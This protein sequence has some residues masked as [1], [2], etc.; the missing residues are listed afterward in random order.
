MSQPSIQPVFVDTV[1]VDSDGVPLRLYHGTRT[2]ITEFD[3]AK[4]VDGGFH[5]GTIDQAKMRTHGAEKRVIEVEIDTRRPRRMFDAGG[6]W[7]QKIEDV[8]R[9]GFDA[10]V[11]L[12]R[13]EGVPFEA[14]ERALAKKIDLDA[15]SD[16]DFRRFVPE[17]RDSWIVF[18]K[19]KIKILGEVQLTD[20]RAIIEG[21][22]NGDFDHEK[23]AERLDDLKKA[24]PVAM[25]ELTDAILHVRE[26][27]AFGRVKSWELGK[28]EDMLALAFAA[29][30]EVKG[31][32][33]LLTIRDFWQCKGAPATDILGCVAKTE[34]VFTFARPSNAE[35]AAALLR[36]IQ[37]GELDPNKICGDVGT[38]LHYA[39]KYDAPE[40]VAV[41]L[42]NGAD[43]NIPN[44]KGQT[45][46]EMAVKF[47]K[48]DVLKPF[49]AK[50]ADLVIAK[51]LR[52]VRQSEPA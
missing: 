43:M 1:A 48:P 7:K 14:V 22:V 30:A 21:Y 37:E 27:G 50:R 23:L 46:Y 19:A 15:I 33:D 35:T 42:A 40:R 34:C 49:H 4:T 13:Y 3:N 51:V 12:N 11:Y 52:G 24:G 44:E 38:P 18:D 39:V 31:R 47:N 36:L 29:G 17:A 6:N 8:K 20:A 10:I 25:R 28:F 45:A 9:A 2:K 5:F 32:D 26:T 16:A 41:L